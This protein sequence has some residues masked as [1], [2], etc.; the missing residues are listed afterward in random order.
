MESRS[1][2][3]KEIDGEVRTNYKVSSGARTSACWL[4][5]ARG[6]PLDVVKKP[7]ENLS[8]TAN[9]NKQQQLLNGFVNFTIDC[10]IYNL[11]DT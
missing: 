2:V 4:L 6:H 3:P 10:S 5:T 11:N 1:S 7:D 9:S 8:F